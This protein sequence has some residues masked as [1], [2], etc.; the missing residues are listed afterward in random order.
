MCC[1]VYTPLCTGRCPRRLCCCSLLCFVVLTF[2]NRQTHTSTYAHRI[3][4]TGVLVC[5]YTRVRT[6][7]TR[8]ARDSL[9]STV[10]YRV[11]VLVAFGGGCLCR[12]RCV[13]RPSASFGY[14]RSQ[15]NNAPGRFFCC[16]ARF[17]NGSVLSPEDRNHVAKFQTFNEIC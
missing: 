1:A 10:L 13:A 7:S 4:C 12:A 11:A 2:E 15:H 8:G 17:I 14:R 6:S 3:I 16:R 9:Y 5:Y